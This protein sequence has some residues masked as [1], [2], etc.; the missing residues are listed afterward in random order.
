QGNIT[1][2]PALYE[3]GTTQIRIVITSFDFQLKKMHTYMIN[4]KGNGLWERISPLSTTIPAIY[5]NLPSPSVSELDGNTSNGLEIVVFNPFES[6]SNW[7]NGKVIVYKGNGDE[8]WSKTVDGQI[9][10]SPALGDLD[11]DGKI[12]VVV[13]SWHYLTGIEP[14]NS[15]VNIY[16]FDGLNGSEKWK[17]KIDYTSSPDFEWGVA[18]PVIAELDKDCLNDVVYSTYNGYIYGI[19]GKNGS[20]LWHLDLGQIAITT[21]PSI[22]DVD[23][24]GFA[25]IFLNGALIVHRIPDLVVSDLVFSAQSAN[26]GDTILISAVI[27]NI[28]TK[29]AEAVRIGFFDSYALEMNEISNVTIDVLMSKTS[30][31]QT[32]WLCMGGGTH[33]IVVIADSNS[34][35]E[36]ANEEN[37][38]MEKSIN[39]SSHYTVDIFC[40]NNRTFLDPGEKHVYF[41]TVKNLGDYKNDIWID[42][43]DSPKD[44]CCTLSLRFVTLNQNESATIALAIQTS[45]TSEAKAYLVIVQAYSKIVKENRDRVITTTIIKGKYGV[46]L[47]PQSQ[48]KDIMQNSFAHFIINLMNVGNTNDTFFINFK[49]ELGDWSV[50]I[51]DNVVNLST[52]ESKNITVTVASPS[53]AKDSDSIEVDIL[54]TSLGDKNKTDIAKIIAKVVIPDITIKDIHFYRGDMEEVDGINKHLIGNRTSY[55]KTRIVNQRGTAEIYGL[56]LWFITNTTEYITLD[57]KERNGSVEAYVLI[58]FMLSPG[59]HIA[60][61]YVDPEDRIN[62]KNETN[63]AIVQQIYLKSEFANTSYIVE[64]YVFNSQGYQI[65]NASVTVENSKGNFL[66]K[67]TD[68]KGRY[69]FE[70]LE[71]GY[72]EEEMIT[73]S[74][75]D[76]FIKANKSFL[77]YS[78]DKRKEINLTLIPGEYDFIITADAYEKKTVPNTIVEYKILLKNLG[79]SGNRINF[80]ISL[81]PKWA[82]ELLDSENNNKDGGN[83][84]LD[85]DANFSLFLRLTVPI[86]AKANAMEKTIVMAEAQDKKISMEFI[87]IVEHIYS[88]SIISKQETG[89]QGE[90]ILTDITVRNLGNGND[91]IVL[92]VSL[93][94]EGWSVF[95]EKTTVNLSGYMAEEKI[96]ITIFSPKNAL[97]G[98]YA[99]II[100]GTSL[101]SK[102]Q[103]KT[104]IKVLIEM[105]RHGLELRF[106]D[107]KERNLRDEDMVAMNLIVRNSGN[108]IEKFSVTYNWVEIEGISM[109]NWNLNIS[110]EEFYLG[111]NKE[112]LV[113]ITIIPPFE[114]KDVV[115]AVLNITVS[116]A[117]I[118]NST[119]A[120][121]NVLRPDFLAAKLDIPTAIEGEEVKITLTISEK[122][123]V[124]G[125][126]NIKIRF[127][128]G[129]KLIR[130]EVLASIEKGETK[131][132]S[133]TWKAK[134][135]VAYIKAEIN[136]S[137][138]IKE[139]NYGN[140]NITKDISVRERGN[141]GCIIIS[142]IIILAVIIAYFYYSRKK[143][144]RMG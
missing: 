144:A 24:N 44:W 128:E 3:F 11:G 15:I 135:G 97:E 101:V 117:N 63:N 27:S 26:E 29:N 137:A 68:A 64:G 17:L 114:T 4:D 53:D 59:W 33:K 45:K 88:F 118:S 38:A 66:N 5:T 116:S 76:G 87:T 131:K 120:L 52:L 70:L 62:E 130:E 36:E 67:K 32:S 90:K 39:V 109:K 12:E 20:E 6:F 14:G 95:L 103:N 136:P 61:L 122:F 124:A 121:I 19:K 72:E 80:S 83:V 31:A 9:E 74:A 46:A 106:T 10:G 81:R 132:V 99:I 22:G 105:I 82:T 115:Q 92:Y 134:V 73:V 18:N 60:T 25:D 50:Y 125:G 57:L 23:K 75:T 139:T 40:E 21:S 140:N 85:K 78:E 79:K 84:T 69:S 110:E 112:K 129:K 56:S 104:I 98:D 127:Y 2:S 119:T 54:A 113:I 1:T 37:N 123:G 51:S 141:F 42:V 142:I 111:G 71:I 126:E 65:I 89:K 7:H 30:E 16:S 41:L 143:Q 91:S 108:V 47:S 138:Q 100:N 35:I 94:P 86:D 28:G 48:K 102:V 96:K 58:P 55:I 133:I 49:G 8:L 13:S 43:I 34:S 77:A 107:G 93:Q